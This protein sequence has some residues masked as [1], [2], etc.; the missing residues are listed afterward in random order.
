M[1]NSKISIVVPCFN[2]EQNIAIFYNEVTTALQTMPVIYELIFIDDGS[3]D[4]TLCEIKQFKDMDTRVKYISF[5]RN[6]GKEAALHAGMSKS[7]GDY[8]AIM[9]VD[10]Q[11]PPSLLPQMYELIQKNC[12]I[13]ATYRNT[14]TGEPIIRSYCAKLFYKLINKISNT[15][16]VDGA[17]DFRLMTRQVVDAILEMSEYNRFSKGIFSW[18]GFKTTWIPYENTQRIAGNSKWSFWKLFLYSIDGIIAFSEV[19]L[20]IASIAG[21]FFF[22]IS[23]IM[24]IVIIIKTLVWGDSTHGWPSLICIIFFISGIQLF[25]TG[26]LGQYLAKTY[27]ETKKRPLHITKEENLH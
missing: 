7:T 20:A 17:R 3:S 10:M 25:C 21:M 4:K 5:S 22:L 13:V 19:P 26:I 27:L 9:D 2:E 6:F 14:R 11:D 18:I 1:E 24:I 8:V 23:I 16:I 15:K 12:D